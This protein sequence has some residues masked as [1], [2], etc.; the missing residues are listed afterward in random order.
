VS[1]WIYQYR[2]ELLMHGRR[3]TRARDGW[4]AVRPPFD[5]RLGRPVPG[6]TTGC[7]GRGRY[8]LEVLGQ[9]S[10]LALAAGSR[11]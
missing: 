6:V 10:C 1:V 5:D 9:G 2:G 8:S 7:G 4:P 11:R 3:L